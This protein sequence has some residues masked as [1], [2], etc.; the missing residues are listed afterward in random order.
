[1]IQCSISEV[2]YMFKV[3]GAGL[4]DEYFKVFEVCDTLDKAK[5]I[6]AELVASF[7]NTWDFL[8]VKEER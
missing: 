1:M 6:L 3:V 7:S 4:Q 8:I 5:E 2:I